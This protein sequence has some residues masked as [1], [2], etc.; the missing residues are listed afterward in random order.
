M[1]ESLHTLRQLKLILIA[2]LICTP[3]FAGVNN[4]EEQDGSPSVYPWKIKVSNGTLTN[5]GDGTAS[6]ATG[7][8]TPGG[9]NTQ[10]QFNDSSAFGG[11][12]GLVYDKTTDILTVGDR[13][14]TNT[15]YGATGY[16][17][18]ELYGGTGVGAD[19]FL[20]TTS[21]ASKGDYYLP[22]LWSASGEGL[23]RIGGSG[24]VNVFTVST[25]K[26]L[27]RATAGTGD[28]EEITLGT[29][30]SFTGTTL[31]AASSGAAASPV[32]S[33][34]FNSASSFGGDGAFTWNSDVNRLGISRD[35][36][37]AGLALVISS[38]TG[39]TLASISHDGGAT[40]DSLTLRNRLSTDSGG[41]SQ[42]TYALGDLLQGNSSASLSKVTI[43][44]MGQVLSADTLA[45]V[46]WVTLPSFATSPLTTKGDL[47]GFSTVDNR[48]PV[49]SM[50]QILSVDTGNANGVTWVTGI[51]SS[52]VNAGVFSM[53]RGGTGQASTTKGDILV[54]TGTAWN[55]LAVGSMG[56]LL[57]VDTAA[58]TGVKW[59]T[60]IVS[61]DVNAGVFGTARGG[62]G[63]GTYA[64][65]DILSGVTGG[66]LSTLG[67]GSMGQIL[68][69]DTASP[70]GF[71]WVATPSSGG[72]P[73]SPVGSIQ[74]NSASTFGGAALISTDAAGLML[75]IG[76]GTSTSISLDVAGSFRT[77]PFQLTDGANI[78]IDTTRSNFYWVTLGGNRTLMNPATALFGQRFTLM[79][80]QDSTGSRKLL[81]DTKFK[82]GADVPSYDASTTATTKDYISFRFNNTSW[83][84]VGVS[85]GYR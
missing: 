23:M 59:V 55:K 39:S 5:N 79:I 26:L 67:V 54:G 66:T 12:A 63:Y 80:S 85:K 46:K 73:G 77:V 53:A 74:Y 49:G 61:T 40:F 25:N 72:T 82:F 60:G 35:S 38:D 44:S 64:K 17:A 11:D 36:G 68:S 84:V 48:V 15:V 32:N 2:L 33:V 69:V 75:K 37:Q 71:K 27:G 29:N 24:I 47:W 41:T 14:V 1:V 10:V 21:N 13:I 62:T 45:G 50:G 31:N 7:A 28:V 22:D 76:P 16:G 70:N 20:Y 58:T 8:G 83:D 42:S 34:Q 65:G 19:L 51:V 9:S 18:L 30:L 52:D 3:V 43:G 57:S 81:F 78:S 4:I 56:Q 6:L